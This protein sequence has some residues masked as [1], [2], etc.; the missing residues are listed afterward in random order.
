M[1]GWSVFTHERIS[2]R[3]FTGSQSILDEPTDAGQEARR[4]TPAS[5]RSPS[6]FSCIAIHCRVDLF[7]PMRALNVREP[8]VW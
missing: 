1:A 5:P 6:T 7:E 4:H 3:G 2:P 8:L